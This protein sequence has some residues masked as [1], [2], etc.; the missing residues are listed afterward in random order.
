MTIKEKIQKN[1]R[2]RLTFFNCPEGKKVHCGTCLSCKK[3]D[4]CEEL[5]SQV[6][7]FEKKSRPIHKLKLLRRYFVGDYL[8][9]KANGSVESAD[10]KSIERRKI[11]KTTKIYKLKAA[12]EVQNKLMSMAKAKDVKQKDMVVFDPGSKTKDKV[13]NL[14]LKPGDTVYEVSDEEFTIVTKLVR[15]PTT[16]R[17]KGAGTRRKR[18]TQEDY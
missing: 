15:K 12:Y 2:L 14:T 5:L 3:I 8:M 4:K 9:I 1:S 6:Q 13:S 16:R 18:K 7:K 17:K 10:D 11:P